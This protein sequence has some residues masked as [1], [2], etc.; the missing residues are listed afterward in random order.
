[1]YSDDPVGA[2]R[3]C[4]QETV[5]LLLQSPVVIPLPSTQTLPIAE[6]WGV[7]SGNSAKLLKSRTIG[8][9]YFPKKIS[10]RKVVGSGDHGPIC[11]CDASIGKTPLTYVLHFF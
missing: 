11:V 6:W 9:Q 10:K 2:V 5:G 3:P 8:N 7:G 1:L 4:E